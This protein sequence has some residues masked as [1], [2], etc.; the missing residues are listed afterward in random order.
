MES[1]EIDW[2][3]KYRTKG[4]DELT[5]SEA[6]LER[7]AVLGPPAPIERLDHDAKHLGVFD[8]PVHAF[9]AGAIVAGLPVG[10][11]RTTAE[12]LSRMAEAGP[13]KHEQ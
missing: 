6:S 9:A 7:A 8:L 11:A 10:A 12:A 2:A 13:R 1:G 3:G 4:D 5:L